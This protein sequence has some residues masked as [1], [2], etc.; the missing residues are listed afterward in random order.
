MLYKFFQK[1]LGNWTS[2]RSYY[3]A[4]KQEVV[5][6]ITNF[7]W[8][9]ETKEDKSYEYYTVKWD[10]KLQNSVGS[11]TCYFNDNLTIK[12]DSGYFTKEATTSNVINCS[13]TFLKTETIY[14]NINNPSV[15]PRVCKM[16]FTTKS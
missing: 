1:S 13:S 2:H 3:Y 7:V 4:N 11:L 12:R 5:N 10:N 15:K 9:K 16:Q 14:N 8:S 6:S